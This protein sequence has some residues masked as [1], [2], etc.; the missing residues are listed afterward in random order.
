MF[1]PER[2]HFLTYFHLGFRV[3][4]E[5]AQFP[6]L[7]K[8]P[9]LQGVAAAV[10][11]NA[12]NIVQLMTFGPEV[13]LFSRDI[14]R[15]EQ[16][17]ERLHPIA[18]VEMSEETIPLISE[19]IN[20]LYSQIAD[21]PEATPDTYRDSKIMSL[22]SHGHAR[23]QNSLMAI[24]R[25]Q[26]ILTWSTFETLAA[27]LWETTLN[28]LPTL[29][30]AFVDLITSSPKKLTVPLSAGGTYL[31]KKHQ[32]TFGRKESIVL[33]YERAFPMLRTPLDSLWASTDLNAVMAVRHL[34][35]H[36]AGIVDDKF[37]EQ[38]GAHPL[39]SSLEVN[40]PLTLT[41]DHVH[42][43]IPQAIKSSF[44]LLHLVDG[45]LDATLSSKDT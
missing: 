23:I 24:M 15:I 6:A 37:V 25:C 33:A 42:A 22:A 21:L 28:S 16:E 2:S 45:W 39:F 34:L 10:K 44:E 8:S 31:R 20:Y 17:A 19:N 35:V 40:K 29:P 9:S 3:N 30:R 26:F 5:L 18:G 27:D 38:I 14:Y 13:Y 1:E 43:L 36:R 32:A 12:D 7:V 4:T 41:G 11:V